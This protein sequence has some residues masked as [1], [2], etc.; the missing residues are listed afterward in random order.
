MG[1]ALTRMDDTIGCEY[2]GF[3]KV[4]DDCI[5]LAGCGTPIEKDA[6]AAVGLLPMFPNKE[7]KASLGF[8]GGRGTGTVWLGKVLLPWKL[9]VGA[10]A[11]GLTAKASNAE[12]RRSAVEARDMTDAGAVVGGGMDNPMDK[13]PLSLDPW[14]LVSLG[15]V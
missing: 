8:P 7:P 9:F 14:V 15:P 11:I 13:R 2:G 10:V 12:N 6:A 4:M 5:G 3:A 1:G